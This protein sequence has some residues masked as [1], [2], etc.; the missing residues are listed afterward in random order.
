MVKEHILVNTIPFRFDGSCSG[1]MEPQTK[2]CKT[3]GYPLG[4]RVRGELGDVRDIWTFFV[5]F[6]FG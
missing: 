1:P 5:V 6:E 3:E 2:T 4:F